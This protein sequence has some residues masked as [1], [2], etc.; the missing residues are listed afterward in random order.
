MSLDTEFLWPLMYTTIYFSECESFLKLMLIYI[1]LHKWHEMA[2][3]F[4]LV[5]VV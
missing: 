2:H 4:I 3:I 1:V 5:K